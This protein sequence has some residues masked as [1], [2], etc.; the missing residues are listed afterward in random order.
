MS[1]REE[2]L[3]PAVGEVFPKAQ[4]SF[5]CQ[6]IA[7][8]VAVSFGNKCRPL[9]WRFA[10]AKTKEAFN[11]VLRELYQESASTADYIENLEHSAWTKYAFPFPRFGHC[12]NNLNESMNNAWLEVRRLPLI[13]MIDAVYSFLMKMVYDRNK[14]PQLSTELSNVPFAKFNERLHSSR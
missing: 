2:G 1:D 7:D 11:E 6:H 8:S 13:Q 10:R 9:F 3:A 14:E 5:C 12:T 4:H